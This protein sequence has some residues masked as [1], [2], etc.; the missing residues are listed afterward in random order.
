MSKNI[1]LMESAMVA[2]IAMVNIDSFLPAMQEY[3]KLMKMLQVT[4]HDGWDKTN[5]PYL[6]DKFNKKIEEC[7]PSKISGTSD[8]FTFMGLLTP[9][10]SIG[11]VR[12]EVRFKI[13]LK[14][15]TATKYQAYVD[16][17]YMGNIEE[18][19]FFDA[20]DTI[21]AAWEDEGKHVRDISDF[22]DIVGQLKNDAWQFLML[23]AFF[24][25]T[26]AGTEAPWSHY[27]ESETGS[28]KWR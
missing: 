13:K 25:M 8:Y 28:S 16:L 4:L 11:R 27:I 20:G 26:D 6:L 3:S 10:Q 2:R 7:G 1:A 15:Q 23:Y 18:V 5:I 19:E 14:S 9:I 24:T 17:P 22:E 21:V 12:I